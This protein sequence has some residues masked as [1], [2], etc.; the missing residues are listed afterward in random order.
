V[1]YFKDPRGNKV[2]QLQEVGGGS[3]SETSFEVSDDNLLDILQNSEE[4]CG[5]SESE[6]EDFDEESNE[7]EG[8]L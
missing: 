1:E 8:G 5:L 4:E 2:S 7:A 6:E 3:S